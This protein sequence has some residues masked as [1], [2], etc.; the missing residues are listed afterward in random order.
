MSTDRTSPPILLCGGTGLLGGMIAARLA[1]SGSG[2]RALVRPAT[3]SEGLRDLGFQIVNGDLREPDLLGAAVEGIRTIVSTTSSLS[4]ALDGERRLSIRAVDVDGYASLIE[5]A[6][7]AGVERF[8]FISAALPPIAAKLAPYAAAKVATEERL[9]RST[10]RPVIVRPDMF[11]EIWLSPVTQ[12]DWPKGKLTIYG[13]GDTGARY[14]AADDV[15]TLTVHLALA[16][17]PPEAVEIGGPEVHTRN[18]AADLFERESGRAMH[19]RHIPRVALRVGAALLRRPN[20]TLA[21]VMGMAL[22]ADLAA[23]T[24]DDGPLL[25][26]GIQPRSTTE[27]VRAVV[28]G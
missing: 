26:A 17:D 16:D 24:W 18:E 22:A 19:R 20:P 1:S 10:L 11:Q 5:A 9:R 7:R 25:A 4:R 14:I 12:F 15:A 28:R 8:V 13:R 6:E 23:P 27:Y 21:S 3:S 2:L